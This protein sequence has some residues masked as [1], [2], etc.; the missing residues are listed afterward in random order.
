L[1]RPVKRS[2]G[3]IFLLVL[4]TCGGGSSSPLSDNQL[5][6]SLLSTSGAVNIPIV[7]VT[8][9]LST[10]SCQ[11]IGNVLVDTGSYGLRL[12]SSALSLSVSYETQSGFT[13]WECAQFGS[14][15]A[16]G[17]VAP[18]SVT[19]AGLTTTS[20]V[21]VQIVIGAS[22]SNTPSS[23]GCSGSNSD[24]LS[25]GINGILGVGLS[26][27]DGGEYD[28]CTSS[29]TSSSCPQAN[30]SLSHS[31]TVYD[32]VA[33]FA[34]DNNGVSL[35]FPSIPAGGSSSISGILAFGVGTQ[36]DNTP[37]PS[38]S[39]YGAPDFCIATAFNGTTYGSYAGSCSSSSMS[40]LDSGSNGLFFPDSSIHLCSGS[41][42]YCPSSSLALN[43]SISGNNGSGGPNTAPI[44]F[45]I[46]NAENTYFASGVLAA[47][48]LG[49]TTSGMF[50]W[51]LP[52]FFG[53]T[54]YVVFN[55]Q[56]SPLGTGPAW[57]F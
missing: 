19:L 37:D 53:R 52:F 8:V 32:P 4:S 35:S 1:N 25:G 26:I 21:P 16:W 13:V 3:F 10:S 43:A 54:I 55:G 11:T 44:A 17:P 36:T 29:S 39:F 12:A 51:G 2:L 56:S 5:A 9:C 23:S 15:D 57:G 24:V 47:P 18:L 45:D 33:V 40:F 41:S 6:V 22:G 50:D 49:G 46:A 28:L 34:M 14:G 27:Y 30:Y 48:D 31:K 42:W 38:V 20:E 7:S